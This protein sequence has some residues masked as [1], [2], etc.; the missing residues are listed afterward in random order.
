MPD[1]AGKRVLGVEPQT[2]R[3]GDHADGRPP[4]EGVELLE[5]RL[6]YRSV[7]AELVDHKPCDARLVGRPERRQRSE[8]MSQHTTAIDVA[9]HDH[10]QIAHLGETHVGDVGRTEI[11]FGGRPRTL[12]DHDIEILAQ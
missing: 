8:Q 9:D 1:H 4:R 12:T 2:L 3:E 11:D 10:R 7:A 5:T 6:Q